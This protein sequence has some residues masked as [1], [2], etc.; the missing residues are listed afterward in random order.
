MIPYERACVKW[1]NTIYLKSICALEAE[2]WPFMYRLEG[3]ILTIGN[4]IPDGTVYH[5][6]LI[7]IRTLTCKM[8]IISY[9]THYI[10]MKCHLYRFECMLISNITFSNWSEF[11]VRVSKCYFGVTFNFLMIFVN[12]NTCTIE[13]ISWLV[14]VHWKL[15]WKQDNT[16]LFILGTNILFSE[17]F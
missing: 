5:T 12:V 9:I 16:K 11:N 8:Y 15:T 6:F 14:V 13:H 3:E 10:L 7:I 1:N 2:L 4:V 17:L